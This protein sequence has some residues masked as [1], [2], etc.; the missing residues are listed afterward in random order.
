MNWFGSFCLDEVEVA[1]LLVENGGKT[2]Y[3]SSNGRKALD[4]AVV[5][6]NISFNLFTTTP[7]SNRK[8]I[9]IFASIILF[10]VNKKMVE[11]LINSGVEVNSLDKNHK[12]ALHRA[13][14]DG[15]SQD[16]QSNKKMKNKT[17]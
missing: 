12:S 14:L 17:K 8:I 4:F 1:E 6:S 15:N 2:N 16:G 9:V 5:H 3:V 13:T 7:N 11:L 10:I